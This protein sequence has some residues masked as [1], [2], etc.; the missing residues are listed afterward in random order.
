M[1]SSQSEGLS[2]S[3][4]ALSF[5]ESGSISWHYLFFFFFPAL[6]FPALLHISQAA[7]VAQW[8]VVGLKDLMILELGARTPLWDVG[9]SLSDE[10]V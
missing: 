1:N 8:L 6:F 5:D 7:R 3:C 10:T 9:A 2:S 4:I